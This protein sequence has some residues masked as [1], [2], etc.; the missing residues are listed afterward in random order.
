MGT[1]N[2]PTEVSHDL[3]R[4]VGAIVLGGGRGTRLYPL[5]Q[6]RAKPAMPLCGRYRLVDIPL[7]NCLHSGINRIVVL[8]QFM[9]HSLNRHINNTY[10]FDA[11]SGGYVEVLS[12]EQTGSLG[13][14]WFQG[15]ADA[16]RKQLIHIRNLGAKH[17]IILS[18]DQLYRMDYRELMATH[19]NKGADITVSALP[20]SRKDVSA[21]GVMRVQRNGRIRQF[22]EKP[23]DPKVIERLVTPD[24]LF[25]E[26]DLPSKGKPYLASM[27]VYVF[28]A[29]VL[30]TLL[31][32]HA[33]WI[34]FGREML[35]NALKTHKIVAHMFSGFWEDV[36]T[37]KAY[38]DVSMAMTGPRPPFDL[39]D[40]QHLIY[41]H[42]RA[43]PGVHIVDSAINNAIICEGTRI[44][45]AKISDSIIGIRSIVNPGA[46]IHRSIILGAEHFETVTG[47]GRKRVPMGI[48]ENSR[49]TQC[50]IDHNAHIG[51]NVVIQGSNKLKDFD[52]D[53]YAIRDGIVVVLKN[54]TIPDGTHIG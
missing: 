20:V 19:V 54:A 35:P 2:T 50:I 52:G 1:Q 32:E 26:F 41:T 33:E 47:G 28:K 21:F 29:K 3:M 30:E 17:Y 23:T 22:V 43:L 53:G 24:S 27:G 7:S 38:F 44:A 49:L 13:D 39:N 51:K 31:E 45:G 34:D 42:A 12:A 5:T 6:V 11:F 14:E 4:R 8:T 9:S 46:G 36:G 25:K 15:T 10:R 48:G 37:V 40:Q 16:V 18:G